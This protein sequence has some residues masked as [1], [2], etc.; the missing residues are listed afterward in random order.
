[1]DKYTGLAKQAVETFFK[2][3]KIM[4]LPKDLPKEFYED[5][6]GVFVTIYNGFNL[7]GCIGTYEPTQENI[8]KEIIANAVSAATKDY[9]FNS[10]TEQELPELKYEISVLSQPEK[11]KDKKELN[12][13]KFGVLV[14]SNGKSGLLLPDLED[15]NTVEQQLSIA[16]QKAGISYPEEKIE[17]YKFSIHKYI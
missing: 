12:A 13:K 10:I 6:A 5:K 17:I 7:R 9:R 14:K 8:G 1:M 3:R 4:D 15:V 16:C 11:I 2:Q